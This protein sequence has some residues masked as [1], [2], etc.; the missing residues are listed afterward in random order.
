MKKISLSVLIILICS[1]LVLTGCT[2]AKNAKPSTINLLYQ[3]TVEKYSNYAGEEKIKIYNSNK[4]VDLYSNSS[5]NEVVFAEIE[6]LQDEAS[7]STVN[8]L[9]EG[10]EYQTIMEA[11]SCFYQNRALIDILTEVPQDFYTSMYERVDELLPI[12]N[13]VLNKKES[14]ESTLKNLGATEVNSTPVK[15]S[16]KS[17]LLSYR[18]LVNKYF[19]INSVFEQLYTTYIF[20]PSGK[21]TRLREGELQRVVLSSAVYLG[22]YYYLKQMVL[23]SQIDNRFAHQKIYNESTHSVVINSNYDESFESFQKIVQNMLMVSD[24]LNLNDP[25]YLTYYNAS[26]DKIKSFR[27]YLEDYKTAVNKILEYQKAHNNQPVPEDSSV[28]EYVKFT[29]RMDI[30]AQNLQNYLMINI[31]RI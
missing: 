26:A 15:E 2:K 6:H 18:N 28:Y 1:I 30:E 8:M 24:P 12:L 14:F 22:E 4:E 9:A 31:M 27:V 29:K 17:F 20:A 7:Y 11:V 5:F 23:N 10:Q 19:E 25:D 21:E 13:D 3:N 16:L